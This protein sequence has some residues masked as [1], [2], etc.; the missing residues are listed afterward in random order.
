MIRYNN[1]II[2]TIFVTLIG[3]ITTNYLYHS[4]NR[5]L[6]MIFAL[7][8]VIGIAILNRDVINNFMNK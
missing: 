8:I 6:S 7:V 3:A 5:N 2:V 1:N 4:I